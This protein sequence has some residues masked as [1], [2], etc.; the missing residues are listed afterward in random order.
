MGIYLLIAATYT[1]ASWSLFRR[2]WRRG[3]L[4]MVWSVAGFCSARIWFGGVLPTWMSTSIYLAMGWGVLFCYR[5]LARSL[6]HRTLLPLP[7]EGAFSRS[8]IPTRP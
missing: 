3:T 1:P 8:D 5:E 4:A 2:S 6:S 7:L